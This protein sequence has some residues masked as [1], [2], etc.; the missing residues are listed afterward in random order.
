M[1]LLTKNKDIT[2]REEVWMVRTLSRAKGQDRVQIRNTNLNKI[3]FSF[4]ILFPQH[5]MKRLSI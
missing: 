3:N 4:H 5:N 2:I 1:I